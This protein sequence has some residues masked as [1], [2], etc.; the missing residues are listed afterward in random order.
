MKI[1]LDEPVYFDIDG[2]LALH[3]KGDIKVDYYGQDKYI[4][5]HNE[6]V[7]FL[8]SLKSRGYYIIAHSGN[9]AQWAANVIEA[10]GLTDFVDVCINKPFKIIDDKPFKEW[11]PPVIFIP[12]Y[13]P[14]KFFVQHG[15]PY[16]MTEYKP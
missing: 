3:N 15:S 2:T 14:A 1:I 13:E 10:L 11:M 4:G 16:K 8:K 5:A 9:G 12:N 7:S 6:H